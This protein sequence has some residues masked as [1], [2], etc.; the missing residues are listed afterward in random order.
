MYLL[1]LLEQNAINLMS[2]FFK[3]KEQSIIDFLGKDLYSIFK[4]KHI[5]KDLPG[6]WESTLKLDDRTLNLQKR[7]KKDYN[8]SFD[9]GKDNY[10]FKLTKDF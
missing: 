2:D 5:K 6:G 8:L 10:Q 4:N 9:F 7:L 1:K 3:E